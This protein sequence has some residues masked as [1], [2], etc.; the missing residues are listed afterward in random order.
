[1][2]HPNRTRC[3]LNIIIVL[4]A[5]FVSQKSYG[6]SIVTVKGFG[7]SQSNAL[8]DAKRNAVGQVC[9]EAISG[10][11]RLETKTQK[12]RSFNSTGAPEKSINSDSTLLNENTASVFGSIKSFKIK[13]DGRAEGD[14]FV[15]IEA[16]VGECPKIDVAQNAKSNKAILLELR[17]I[18]SQI[19]NLSNNSG[20]IDQPKTYA[21][22][23]HNARIYAQRGEVDLALV[24][25]EKLLRY[26][27]QMADPL[28]DLITLG[29]R[30]YGLDGVKIYIDKKLKNK[31]PISSYLFAQILM[32]EPG[33]E[34]DFDFNKFASR[35]EWAASAR[36][37]PPLAYQILI[38]SKPYNYEY[39]QKT[40]SDWK[41]YNNLFT[42]TRDSMGNGEFFSYYID[43]IRAGSN[44]EKY[45]QEKIS[46]YFDRYF[47]FYLN[48]N[49]GF[50]KKDHTYYT[51]YWV[52]QLLKI[53]N[54]PVITQKRIID[55]EKS[56]IVLD[57]TYYFEN[58]RRGL[59]EDGG[60][61]NNSKYDRDPDRRE[62]NLIEISVWD[63][64]VDYEKPFYI[65]AFL[66]NGKEECV[67]LNTESYDCSSN[68]F[69]TEP[70]KCLYIH[71]RSFN[72]WRRPNVQGTF[73]TIELFK[74]QCISKFS[75]TDGDGYI[76][77]ISA[78]DMIGTHAWPKGRS[79]NTEIEDV[80][81]QCRYQQQYTQFVE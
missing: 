15:E 21:E 69:Q 47:S 44:L 40:W 52:K 58:P 77:E 7:E 54:S 3:Y 33:R 64:K 79:G 49:L 13:G 16:I 8:N 68:G 74:S 76:V 26:P 17:Q 53:D 27:V 75:Y 25:Y 71:E 56:P 67:N 70:Y 10:S 46:T 36:T 19:A 43:Q 35:E 31:M 30:A 63:Q 5:L 51:S 65:C 4:F 18:S 29:K 34:A 62:I 73:S 80:I 55:L 81:K 48:D 41:F 14:F 28:S 1:M 22:I 78:N 61:Y 24:A 57:F 39:S 66:K 45:S 60:Y 2:L 9:G 6:Q 50:S 11:T 38:T 72:F 37:F 20:V 42:V 32:I 23:Y 59:V 12:T